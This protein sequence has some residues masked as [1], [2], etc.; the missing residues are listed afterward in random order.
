MSLVN[1]SKVFVKYINEV[2]GLGAFANCNIDK[3][4]LIECGVARVIDIDGNKNPY[5]FTW[6]EDK[7]IWAFGSGCSTFYNT[8]L[9]PN[10]NFV[11]NYELNTFQIYALHDI[12][13]GDELTHKY[14]SLEWRE[15][16]KD[17]H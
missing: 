17:L 4:K 10:C 7:K 3:G 6:S 1:C 13:E 15:C 14:K 8:S 16:F 2:K 9:N 11:R 12:K 5:V